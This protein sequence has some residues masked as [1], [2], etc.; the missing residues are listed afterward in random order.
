MCVETGERV[1]SRVAC[2]QTM[3]FVDN[4]RLAVYARQ[5]LL[6]LAPAAAGAASG[7][8]AGAAGSHQRAGS[9]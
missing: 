5:L 4:T 3:R 1:L 8:G 9:E 7:G 2:A 6:A